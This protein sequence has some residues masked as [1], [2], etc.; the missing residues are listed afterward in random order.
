M[1]FTQTIPVDPDEVLAMV[2]VAQMKESLRISYTKEDDFIRDCILEAYDWLAG[3]QG[4][5]NRQV[6]STGWALSLTEFAS[7]IEIPLTPLTGISS[8]GYFVSAAPQTVATSVYGVVNKGANGLGYVYLKSGEEWPTTYD[9]GP[10]A[11]TVNAMIGMGDGETVR[12]NHPAL[13]KALKLLAGDYF[14]IREDTFTDIRMVEIDR[15]VVNNV[16][17]VAGRYKLFNDRF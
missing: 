2:S 1:S 14:R 6:I 15:K 12:N 8:I 5:L 11:I 17:R 16:E 9:T 10:Q 3:P 7:V 4:W 13:V